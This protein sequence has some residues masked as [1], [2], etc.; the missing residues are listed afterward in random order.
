MTQT[1]AATRV[2]YRQL[3]ERIRRIPGVEAADISA[4]LPLARRLQL[5][6]LL[7]WFAATRFDGGD[8]PG[9]YYW[10][11][12]EYLSTLRIPLLRGRF[13]SLTD[14]VQSEKV[15]A[16]DSVLARTYFPDRDPIGETITYRIGAKPGSWGGGSCGTSRLDG[17]AKVYDNPQIYGCFYQLSDLWIPIVS[18]RIKHGGTDAARPRQVMPAI[19]ERGLRSR[20]AINRST[21]SA[22]CRTLFPDRWRGSAFPMI[23]LVTF[24]GVALLLASIGI[25]G[26]ISYSTAQRVPEIGIRMALGATGRDVTQMLV[27]QGLRLA[28]T[29]IAIGVWRHSCSPGGVEFFPPVI[30]G[31][32]SRS[33]DLRCG[34]AV[35][36]Q[37]GFGC[38]LYSGPACGSVGADHRASPGISGSLIVV[39]APAGHAGEPGRVTGTR[40]GS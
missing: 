26:L 2:A 23:L 13:V 12:P 27:G 4:L 39:P 36:H 3:V 25:Y 14:T 6:P 8:S 15:I 5:G 30:R 22:R 37:R 10:T 29:G 38:L 9:R 20:R 11:G 16:I 18:S 19:T 34:L 24:A 28:L 21:M 40:Q 1:A 31:A 7:A 17:S 32:G 35:V 33:L